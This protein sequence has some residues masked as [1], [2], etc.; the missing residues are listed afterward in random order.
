MGVAEVRSPEA[1]P[2]MEGLASLAERDHEFFRRD[3]GLTQKTCEGSD[4]DLVMHRYDATFGFVLHDNVAAALPDF[5]KSKTFEC[6]LN[7]G[8]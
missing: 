8:A 5:L 1:V 6:A 4:L 3:L 2:S 7:L